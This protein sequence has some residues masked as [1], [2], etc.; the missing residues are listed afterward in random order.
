MCVPALNPEDSAIVA[1]H[2]P[3]ASI[4]PLVRVN[5]VAFP[6][7]VNRTLAVKGSPFLNCNALPLSLSIVPVMSK[8]SPATGFAIIGST[9]IIVID[10]IVIL[11]K[12]LCVG[13]KSKLPL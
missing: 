5:P 12:F 13:N 1:V 6:S 7:K 4:C 10:L 11:D 8:D 2:D 9:T 3:F